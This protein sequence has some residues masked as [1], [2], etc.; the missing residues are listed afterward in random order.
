MNASQINHARTL[1]I[2]ITLSYSLIFQYV[3]SRMNIPNSSRTNH[4]RN[5]SIQMTLSRSSNAYIRQQ[6][7]ADR[8]QTYIRIFKEQEQRYDKIYPSVRDWWKF[9]FVDSADLIMADLGIDSHNQCDAQSS[10]TIRITYNGIDYDFDARQQPVVLIGKRDESDIVLNEPASSR[11]HAV[12]YLFPQLN[13]VIIVDIG[14]RHGITML[15]R[16]SSGPL[17]HSTPSDRQ[18]IELSFG[19]GCQLKLGNQIITLSPLQCV[20]C[21]E[22]SRSCRLPCG[23]F[24]TCETCLVQ[25]NQCPL[26]RESF[27]RS[28]VHF[29]VLSMNTRSMHRR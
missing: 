24:V 14:S 22:E 26:C 4:A 1:S 18:T 6:A 9:G 8:R 11:L 25:I 17:Q 16:R 2:Q 29:R 19:E 15:N 10:T 7:A 23:H 3:Q 28:Q 21:M 27:T 13:K 5:L 20:I 12:I